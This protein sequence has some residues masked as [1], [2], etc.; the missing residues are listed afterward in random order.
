MDGS[1]KSSGPGEGMCVLW[2]VLVVSRGLLGITGSGACR[3]SSC[4]AGLVALRR[5][6]S[7]FP[8]EGSNLIPSIG[9]RSPTTGPPGKSLQSGHCF[10][11]VLYLPN[12]TWP[13]TW[14][15]FPSGSDS[16]ESA[17][18]A[19]DQGLTPGSEKSPGEGNGNPLQYSC[20]EIPMDGGGWQ[21]PIYGVAKS[22]TRLSNWHTHTP[23]IPPPTHTHSTPI[24]TSDLS[25]S[26][27]VEFV[28]CFPCAKLTSL[29]G[30]WIQ[31]HVLFLKRM[32]LSNELSVK[33]L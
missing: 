19:G 6:G 1:Q 22:Q 28:V 4:A 12:M 10:V 8:D 2:W 29:F 24:V 16:K 33:C 3:L 13:P 5:V 32:F 11:V 15:V 23:Y 9:R 14:L 17:C 7:W 20:L 27:L 21:A 25:L 18:K 31:E 30:K 26:L